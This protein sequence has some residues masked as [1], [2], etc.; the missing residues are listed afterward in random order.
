MGHIHLS[1]GQGAAIFAM[2]IHVHLQT[3]PGFLLCGHSHIFPKTLFNDQTLRDQD[4]DIALP[5]QYDTFGHA[6]KCC[7]IRMSYSA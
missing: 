5:L 2:Y 7:I 1:C 3:E 4:R 6:R